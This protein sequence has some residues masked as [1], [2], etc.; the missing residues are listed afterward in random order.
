MPNPQSLT[1]TGAAEGT[2][3]GSSALTVE[4]PDAYGATET[5]IFSLD[6][7]EFIDDGDGT[8][9]ASIDMPM[10]FTEVGIYK[11][12][13]GN[14]SGITGISQKDI[15]DWNDNYKEHGEYID[16]DLWDIFR[17]EKNLNESFPD[18]LYYNNTTL[19]LYDNS[20]EAGEYSVSI[21][22]VDVYPSIKMDKVNPTAIGSFSL[23]RKPGSAIGN[24]S[25]AEGQLTTASGNYSHAEGYNTTA[26]ASCSHAEGSNTTASGPAAHAE[27]YITTASGR[28]SHAEGQV[29]TAKSENQHVQGKYNIEDSSGVYADIIGNGIASKKSN[30]ATVDWSGNAW[31]AGDVYVGSTSGTN[32]DKGSKKLATEEYVD[33]STANI[34]IPTTL[35][36]PQ[37]LTFTGAVNTSYDGSSEV[38]VEIPGAL[39]DLSEDT[40]HRVVTDAEKA[41]WNAKSNF[42]GSYNDLTDKPTIP[43]VPVQSV[44]G[45]TGAVVLSAEDVGAL[46]SSTV[47]PKTLPNPNAIT[48]TGAVEGTY[49]GSNPLTVEIPV[50]ADGKSAYQYAQ[51]GGYTGTEAEFAEKLASGDNFYIDLAGSDLNYTCSMAMDDI[52]AAYNAGY[53]LVC[54]CT[55][56]AYV[57][58]LPLFLPMP[59]ANLWVF[60]GSG[61]LNLGGTRF[62]PQSFTVAIIGGSVVAQLT[63]FTTKD[64]RLPNPNAINFTGAVTGS[65]DGSESLSINIPSAVTD[66]HIN[67]L[68][69]TALNAIGVAEERAY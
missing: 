32:K 48:F 51:D 54:R 11:V 34:D 28:N 1:F 69:N 61:A 39:S 12:K 21:T 7:V 9:S 46:P 2:Y 31:Y 6:S 66:A 53:N 16:I 14:R 15:D 52:K 22:K 24:Y 35:P 20:I 37:S 33:N 59:N 43:D 19:T 49:D 65:Y 13:I 5:V 47:I 67:E 57:A 25:H 17:D 55:L 10:P 18:G 62:L 3:D 44:N 50:G 4:I 64:D 27:G 42:S 8:R 41:K 45:K 26:S 40:T 60:S 30:A 38:S 29:T 23:N 58:T 63:E 56:D 68:I 36:N